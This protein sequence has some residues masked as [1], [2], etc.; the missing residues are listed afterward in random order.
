MDN[1]E[2]DPSYLFQEAITAPGKKLAFFVGPGISVGSGLPNFKTF[3]KNL[4][5]SIGPLGW[6]S[7]EIDMICDNLRPEVLIQAIQQ[8]LGDSILEFFGSLDSGTANPNHYFLA[9]ALKNGHC[10]FTTNVDTLIE[11]ACK[12][13]GVSC[14]LTV[15]KNDYDSL[16]MPGDRPQIDFSSRLFK[17]HGSIASHENGLAKYESIRF[18]LDRVGLGL[19]GAQRETLTSCLSNYDFVFL[20]YSGNDHFSVQPVLKEDDPKIR[21]KKIYWFQFRK[22]PSSFDIISGIKDFSS[23][24]DE[25]LKEA[26]NGNKVDWKIWEEISIREVLSQRDIAYLIKGDSCMAIEK[27][28]NSLANDEAFPEASSLKKALDNIPIN[29]SNSNIRSFPEWVKDISEF[30][31]HLCAATLMVRLRNLEKAKPHLNRAKSCASTEEERAEIEKLRAVTDSIILQTGK[32]PNNDDLRKAIEACQKKGSLV[33]MV[34]ACLE[35]ANLQRID[36]MFDLAMKTLDEAEDVLKKPDFSNPRT[37]YDMNRLMAQMLH[38]RGLVLGLGLSGEIDNKLKGIDYCNRALDYANRAG[39][40]ERKAAILNAYGI[41]GYQLAEKA[42]NSLKV[43]EGSSSDQFNEQVVNYLQAAESSLYESL[44][45]YARLLDPHRSF[46]PLRNLMLVHLLRAEHSNP[47]DKDRWY[48]EALNDVKRGQRYLEQVNIGSSEPSGDQIELDFRRAHILGKLGD[49]EDA[50]SG[51]KL[52]LSHWEKKN[53]K[54]QQTRSWLELLDLADDETVM[55][56]C[57]NKL[58]EIVGIILNSPEERMRY[59]M[60][61]LRLEN[62]W[63]M[64][65]NA[66]IAARKIMDQDSLCKIAELSTTIAEIKKSAEKICQITR[67][68]GTKYETPGTELQEAAKSLSADDLAS[69]QNYSTKIVWQLK[70]FCHQLPPEDKEQVCSLVEEIAHEADFPEKLH[71]ILTALLCLSPVLEGEILQ[72]IEAKVDVIHENTKFL[73]LYLNNIE[74]AILNLKVSS[75]NAKK[76]LVDIKK[77]IDQLQSE[78]ETQGLSEKEL[79]IALEDKDH[80]MIERLTKMQEHMNRAVRDIS[81]LSASKRDVETILKKL[82]EQ[83]GFKKRDALGIISDMSQLSQMALNIYLTGRIV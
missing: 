39:D 54:H 63:K 36:R 53:N 24:R 31:R 16:I 45:L 7:K 47:L 10:I 28:L 3:S 38:Y 22:D 67:G 56:E 62:H 58:V 15:D 80:A 17:L 4:I 41:I 8:V 61:R 12:Q 52:V 18:A 69:V 65:D 71:K 29:I 74:F 21:A 75:G 50:R 35:L 32:K 79:T 57:V 78:I 70:K 60:D 59:K 51:Q 14:H 23:Q 43:A 76:D 11:Q 6:D 68:S 34:E 73:G 42:Y 9:L 64:L 49:K 19:I 13:L 48:K 2:K 27:V 40:I 82:D 72:R 30:K 1:F 77:G 5:S 33:H 44:A 46:Q 26:L 20:G 66:S 55:R 25:L 83:D 81:K 37:A